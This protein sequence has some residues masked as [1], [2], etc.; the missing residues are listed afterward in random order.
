[1]KIKNKTHSHYLINLEWC[2]YFKFFSQLLLLLLLL[3]SLSLIQIRKN[4]FHNNSRRAVAS[5]SCFSSH[6]SILICL[7]PILC[8]NFQCGNNSKSYRHRKIEFETVLNQV[9]RNFLILELSLSVRC[10]R[11]FSISLYLFSCFIFSDFFSSDDISDEIIMIMKVKNFFSD[12][13]I[14]KT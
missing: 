10:G 4:P 14:F 7:C 1:V 5:R 8:H 2:Y 12:I 6:I 3:L 9:W 13:F 11:W